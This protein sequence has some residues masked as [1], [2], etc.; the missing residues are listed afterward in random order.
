MPIDH[1]QLQSMAFCKTGEN[2]FDI[3]NG[4]KQILLS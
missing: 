4:E 2:R 1:H 3:A